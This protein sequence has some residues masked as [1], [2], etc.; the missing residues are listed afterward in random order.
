MSGLKSAVIGLT[1]LFLWGGLSLSSA[2]AEDPPRPNAKPGDVRVQTLSITP[3]ITQIITQNT[4]AAADT[5]TAPTVPVPARKAA[6]PE[7]YSPTIPAQRLALRGDRAAKEYFGAAAKPAN[8]RARSIGSYAKGCLAGGTFLPKDGN[9][10]QVMRLSRNRNWGHPDLIDYLQDLA[11]DAP[12]LGWS[13]LL[14]GDLAQPRGGPMTSGHASHQIGLDADIWLRQMPNRRLSQQE[15]EE[16][17]AISMLKGPLDVKGADRSVDP[18][19]WT[20]AH[21]RLIRRAAQDRRVAR[22]FVNPTIKKAL[23]SFE[24]GPDRSWLRKVRSWWGHHYHF[25]VRLSCPPD[26]I[27]C[28]NQN[29]PP[30]G[31]GCGEELVYWLSDVPWVPNK[32]K[33]P[34]KKPVVKKKRAMQLA[35]L[36]ND[37]RSVLQAEARQ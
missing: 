14:V 31:D 4:K 33:D 22:I 3:D 6:V 25:H 5:A 16:I 10:W 34:N 20:D 17:S 11:D 15:R 32:P 21:A 27:G 18:N 37:C 29:P 13:G 28:K 9:T 26:S 23:C 36:P 8:L 35:A 30:P 1:S 2:L 7:G 24:R 19:K 12:S